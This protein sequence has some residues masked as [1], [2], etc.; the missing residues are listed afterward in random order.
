MLTAPRGGLLTFGAVLSFYFA[1][2]AIEALRVGLNRAY[3]L[4]ET[5]PWWLLRLQ[6]IGLVLVGS[7]ALLALAFLVVLGPLIL[8]ALVGLGSRGRRGAQLLTFARLG[9]AALACWRVSLVLAHRDPARPPAE[10]SSTR[11][12]RD[13]DLRRQHRLRRGFRRLSERVRAQLHLDLRGPRVGDDRARLSLLGGALVRVRR[14]TQRS[15]HAGAQPRFGQPREQALLA[16]INP[17]F[18]ERWFN[19]SVGRKH[20]D[21]PRRL[22]V[23]LAPGPGL[24]EENDAQAGRAGGVLDMVRGMR[25]AQA[26]EQSEAGARK[27]FGGQ[28]QKAAGAER[29]F[30]GGENRT[31]VAEITKRVGGEDQ[32][33]GALRRTLEERNRVGRLQPV[34]EAAG[35]R[36]RDHRGRKV[37]TFEARDPIADRRA[38]EPG[39]AAEVERGGEAAAG[40]DGVERPDQ[41]GR[42][43]VGEPEGEMRPRSVGA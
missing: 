21:Q 6:S 9:V 12:G 23:G 35:P 29:P 39:A 16:Q 36:A 37:N 38:H 25:K 42:A 13:V 19:A 7:L 3:G 40:R 33:A 14:R 43:A 8:D 17:P 1:S 18:I 34:V 5:R 11:A 20:C 30:G 2:S 28:R 26:F 22:D 27:G 4:V 10:A 15:D 32:V 41:E 24:A 31:E